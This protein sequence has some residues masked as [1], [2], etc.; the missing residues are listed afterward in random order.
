M[1][2]RLAMCLW[3]NANA[4]EA[5]AHYLS[6]FDSG[7]VTATARYG[8]TGPGPAGSV[9]TIA[10]EIEDQP[11]LALNGGP[12]FRSRRRPQSSSTATLRKRSTLL[13]AACRGRREGPLRLAHR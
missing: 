11:F 2:S 6:I 5:V 9:M 13:G 3:F 12:V 1:S 8:E 4:E 10:F 7:R